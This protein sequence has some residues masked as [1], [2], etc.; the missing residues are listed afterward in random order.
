MKKFYV[1]QLRL[2]NCDSPFYIG[3]GTGSRASSHLTTSSMKG[4]SHKNN[5]IR[6]ALANG[7]AVLV[8]ILHD[9]LTD[10]E[11]LEKEVELI[12]KFGRKI[13]GGCLTNATDG[14]DGASGYKHTEEAKRK[15][16]ESKTG[17]QN[18][19]SGMRGK[20]HNPET[21]AKMSRVRTGKVQSDVHKT[22]IKHGQWDKNPAWLHSDLIFDKWI[23]AGR[24]GWKTLAKIVDGY[25]VESMHR[26]F[27]SGW[28]PRED[29]NWISYR[30]IRA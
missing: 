29:A 26:K 21:R 18:N 27:M 17:N 25:N 12:A 14:G 20:A 15:I 1:Y 10:R 24:P 19:G 3:K 23:S 9:G 16:A 13:N 30:S 2:E 4:R 11:A 22:S 28:N 6:K 7:V 5:V 8:E